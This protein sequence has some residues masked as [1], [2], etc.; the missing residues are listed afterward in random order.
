[1]RISS[2]ARYGV[3][4]MA[5]L[6]TEYDNEPVSL[7]EIAKIEMI[8]EAYLAQLLLKFKNAA[9]ITTARGKGGGYV[10]L[11]DAEDI[12][13]IDMLKAVEE[14]IIPLECFVNTSICPLTAN[15]FTKDFWYTLKQQIEEALSGITLKS[16]LVKHTESASQKKLQSL[17]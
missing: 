8:D 17:L 5:R 4:A 14:E 13:L 11:K 16:I 10:P 1:M 9:L 2:K 6:Y 7:K 15:C 3:R 12:T